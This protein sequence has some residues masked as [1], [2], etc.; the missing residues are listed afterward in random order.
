MTHIHEQVPVPEQQRCIWQ[1]VL[2]K[3]NDIK[4]TIF[5]WT[6]DVI[7]TLSALSVAKISLGSARTS[8]IQD[9][10]LSI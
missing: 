6:K 2:M 9:I 8:L 3:M 10:S 5:N 4:V 1:M 7:I